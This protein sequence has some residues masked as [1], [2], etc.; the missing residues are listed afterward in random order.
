VKL[1]GIIQNVLPFVGPGQDAELANIKGEQTV[2][3]STTGGALEELSP[4]G[5]VI[6]T[7]QQTGGSAAFGSA[8]DA[9][10]KSGALN[11][12]ESASV[13]DLL[14]TGLPDVVKYELSLEDAANLL[15]V[16]QNF[17]YNHL[18]GAWDGSTAKPLEAYPTVTDDFQFLSANDIAKIDPEL[19]TNQILAGTGLGLVHAYDG[20][21]GQDVPGFPKVTGGWIPAPAS[22]SWDGRMAVTTREGYLF[23]WQTK[24]PACQPQWPTFRHDQQNSGNYNEDGTPPNAPENMT[25]T[26]VGKRR[27]HLEFKAPGDDGPC[28][29]PT[30]YVTY[31]NGALHKLNLTPAAGGST[32]STEI[33]TAK[34]E[35]IHT[36]T[37]QALDKGRNLGPAVTVT[38]KKPKRK[39]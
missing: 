2:I 21:T 36:L 33:A 30:S 1:P 25:L 24:A 34:K 37:L 6:R 22:L 26:I 17:P 13:G 20:A 18:I 5:T 16:G 8:S 10:D 7:M 38:A 15:L 27:Y 12:F 32:F 3:A 14:G 28:G 19:P 29:T 4:T 11:L 23:E 9:T 35:R 31:V 39:R